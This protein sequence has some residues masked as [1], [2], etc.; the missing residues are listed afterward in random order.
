[1]DIT[2][3]LSPG[4]ISSPG[5]WIMLWRYVRL[6]SSQTDF[7]GELDKNVRHDKDIQGTVLFLGLEAAVF[8]HNK[9]FATILNESSN[10]WLKKE[11]FKHFSAFLGLS[12]ASLQENENSLLG[13]I[14]KDLIDH[15]DYLVREGRLGKKFG[16]RA[17]QL[18]PR[19]KDSTICAKL[20]ERD[21]TE[22]GKSM[23]D[24]VAEMMKLA[25]VFIV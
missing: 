1:M 20:T 24:A 10:K 4:M 9:E 22:A 13:C 11:G 19:G 7:R 14:E 25:N 12:R 2:K 23:E 17:A 16:K 8:Y 15:R 21:K 5:V 6:G 3:R 18:P